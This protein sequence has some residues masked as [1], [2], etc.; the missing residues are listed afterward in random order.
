MFKKIKKEGEKRK[1][2][3]RKKKRKKKRKKGKRKR[4]R[5]DSLFDIQ[6][7][8]VQIL[9]DTQANPSTTANVIL[10]GE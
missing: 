3:E 5:K 1:K 9:A 6:R 7:Y 4:K 10:L 2:K 8:G